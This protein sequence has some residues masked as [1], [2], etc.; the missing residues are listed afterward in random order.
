MAE[1][2]MV[3]DNTSATDNLNLDVQVTVRSIAGWHTGFGRI[4]GSGDVN[5]TPGGSARLTRNEIISQVQAG[6]KLFGGIDGNGNH[7]TLIIED[8]PTCEYLNFKCENIFSDKKVKEVFDIK[9]QKAFEKACTNAFRTRAEKYALINAI[10][11]LS[12]NDYSK[13]R[14]TEKYTGFRVEN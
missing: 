11:R 6:N 2:E 9:T 7:A 14:F 4:I 5:F 1:T 13:I 3:A 8:A 10:R 12:I